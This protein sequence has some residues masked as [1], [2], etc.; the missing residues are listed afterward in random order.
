MKQIESWKQITD[1]GNYVK[2]VWQ[3]LADHHHLTITQW[4]LPALAGYTISSENS[5][6]Y[7]TLITQEMLKVGYLASTSLYASTE[8]TPNRIDQ[9]IDSLSPIFALISECENGRDVHTLLEGPVC[10][11]GFKRLN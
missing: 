1:N 8:H 4:G 2:S 9:Y 10:H 11:G 7:K 6:E 3:Q 5:L